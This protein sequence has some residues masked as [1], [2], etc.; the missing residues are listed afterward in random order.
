MAKAQ[1]FD[2]ALLI[3]QIVA[4]QSIHY[5]ALSIITP[6]LLTLFANEE[7]LRYEWGSPPLSVGLILDWRELANWEHHEAVWQGLWIKG[8]QSG[9]SDDIYEWDGNHNRRRGWLLAISWVLACF[10]DIIPLYY[11]VRKPTLILDF[12]VTMTGLHFL[13]TTAHV[14]SPP[15]GFFCY[16]IYALGVVVLVVGAEQLAMRRELRRG[17]WGDRQDDYEMS[18]R[19]NYNQHRRANQRPAGLGLVLDSP[20]INYET[21]KVPK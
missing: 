2:A 7:G 11:L 12:A 1:K 13:F 3:F 5:L 10:I 6:T 17:L 9:Y 4:V 14:Q 16:G 18:T 20:D 8:K 21:T 15:L 19:R